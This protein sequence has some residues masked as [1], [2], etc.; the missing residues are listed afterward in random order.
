MHY[1]GI[2]RELDRLHSEEDP[3]V[4]VGDIIELLEKQFHPDARIRSIHAYD[5]NKVTIITS[6]AEGNANKAIAWHFPEDSR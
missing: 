2:D 4:S 3:S 1:I 6:N 5:V